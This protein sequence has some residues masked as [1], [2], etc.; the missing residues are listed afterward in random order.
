M[1]KTALVLGGGGARGA[2]QVGAWQALSELDVPVDI[3]TGTS[4]GALNAAVI[5][6]GGFSDV[7]DL[8]RTLRTDMVF[9]IQMDTSKTPKQQQAEMVRRVLRDYPQKG[10]M[11][12]A[13]LRSLIEQYCSEEAV[14][15][16]AIRCGIVCYDVFAAKSVELFCDEMKEGQ[17]IDY[18]LA[19]SAVFP[20]VKLHEVDGRLMAD[21][22]YSDN[23]PVGL[24]K[25]GGADRFILVELGNTFE[26]KPTVKQA[27][28]VIRIHPYRD[29]GSMLVFDPRTTA[30][31]IRLGYLDTMKVCGVYEGIAFTF[32]KGTFARQWRRR[33]AEIEAVEAAAGLHF[34]PHP[35]K[36]EEAFWV[37]IQTFLTKKYRREASVR[38][39]DFLRAC[40]ECAGEVFGL[41]DEKI[42]SFYRFNERL[43]AAQKEVERPVFARMDS[44]A[45]HSSMRLFDKKVRVCVIADL[46]KRAVNAHKEVNLLPFALLFPEET[47]AGYYLAT[48]LPIES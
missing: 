18:L 6:S 9:D 2:Y 30:R 27:K 28:Q 48:F 15:K 21:G 16:S 23:L 36:R 19:S 8:W 31:N 24:A 44:A 17:L 5:A 14:R 43:V 39:V 45:L 46:L 11:G 1:G 29:L 26:L 3:V 47:L 38:H 20:A 25:R 33:T 13:P 41:C 10:A 7:A 35:K 22:G 34:S 32:L 12:A 37:R 42:Y 4:V 40:A